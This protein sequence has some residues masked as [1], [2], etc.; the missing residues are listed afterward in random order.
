M[1]NKQDYREQVLLLLSCLL[2]LTDQNKFALKGGTA[3]NFFID[4]L[5]RLSVDIDLTYTKLLPIP[6]TIKN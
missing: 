5:P 6:K 1:M 2:A 4:E 3:I